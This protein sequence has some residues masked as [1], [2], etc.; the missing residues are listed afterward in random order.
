MPIE[1]NGIL[2]LMLF[3]NLLAL[4]YMLSGSLGVESF[5]YIVFDL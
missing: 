5:T 2:F 1:P 4:G 3:L